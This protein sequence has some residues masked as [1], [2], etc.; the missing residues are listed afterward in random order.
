MKSFLQREDAEDHKLFCGCALT[1][2]D[3]FMNVVEVDETPAR[4][5]ISPFL[6][7]EDRCDSRLNRDQRD[8][9]VFRIVHRFLLH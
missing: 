9:V 8:F 7:F 2:K 4:F 6:R 1:E 5:K 3:I